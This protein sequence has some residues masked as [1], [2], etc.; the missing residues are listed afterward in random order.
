MVSLTVA[1]ISFVALMCAVF[2]K[3]TIHAPIAA[4][5]PIVAQYLGD[6]CLFTVQTNFIGA[7]YFLMC[8]F[9]SVG[10][11]PLE[12]VVRFAPTIFALGAF[13]TIGYY[14]I[15]HFDPYYQIGLAFAER[16]NHP[17]ARLGAH[18]DHCL[19]LGAVGLHVIFLEDGAPPLINTL[20]ITGGYFLFYVT[21]VNVNFFVTGEWVYP[22]MAYAYK[23]SGIFGVFYV[24]AIL[25][26]FVI[27]L[28]CLGWYLL[29]N[30]RKAQARPSM[31]K[32]RDLGILIGVYVMLTCYCVETGTAQQMQFREWR[33]SEN[34]R[35]IEP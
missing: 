13:V 14:G 23:V 18:L 28:A 2:S 6:F 3:C 33:F 4:F 15:C 24:Q 27:A 34:F 29:T 11:L 9:A 35:T 10:V 16:Q 17:W 8:I 19:N 31:A 1:G 20:Q 12:P 30:S 21:L 25:A 26:G 5:N 32:M 7:L 22:F